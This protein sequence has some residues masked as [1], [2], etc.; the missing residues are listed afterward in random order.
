MT[1]MD[2]RATW[3]RWAVIAAIVAGV[4]FVPPLVARAW[5]SGEQADGRG[6]SGGSDTEPTVVLNADDLSAFEKYFPNQ[7]GAIELSQTLSLWGWTP[8]P[9]YGWVNNDGDKGGVIVTGGKRRT[10][11]VADPEFTVWL[12]GG[13]TAFGFG[14]RDEHTIASEL[15]KLAEED[16]IRLDV[17]NYGV[18]GWVNW[19]ETLLF[20]DE[21]RAGRRPDVAVFLDGA[22][23][24]ALGIE[25]EK[26]GLL[27][28]GSTYNQTMTDEQREVLARN[29]EAAG[30]ES[31][32]DLD[33][34]TGLAADQYR[35]G[36]ERS[37]VLGD[38]F[39]VPVM[40]YWQP[41]LYTIPRDRPLVED[42]LEQWQIPA[43]SHDDLGEVVDRIAEESGVDPIDLTGIYDDV[44]VPVFYDTSH[45]NEDGARIEAEA[46]WETLGPKL[47]AM[48]RTGT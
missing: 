43:D 3:K 12:F 16:G 38:E 21:L 41:Q 17:E 7:P 48:P 10:T 44:E 8:H 24:T 13:S 32:G 37:K 35:K 5:P 46:I 36:V 42:A 18:S 9:R 27:D 23:D 11:E 39:G 29:A 2:G 6:G 15:V 26:Y 28:T 30:Y 4:L 25:R 22:N 19:Q 33:V 40:H 14:Q 34:V 45:T 20:E 47:R 1:E 31:R